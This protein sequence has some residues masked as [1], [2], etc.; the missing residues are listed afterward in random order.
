MK[1][2][3]NKTYG[4]KDIYKFYTT[5]HKKSLSVYKKEFN[6]YNTLVNSTKE[7]IYAINN[8]LDVYGV[9]EVEVD[10]ID[11][12][13]IKQGKAYTSTNGYVSLL[14]GYYSQLRKHKTK[15]TE[16][17]TKVVRLANSFLSEVEFKYIYKAYNFHF[18]NA[19]LEGYRGFY[20]SSSLGK[21]VIDTYKNEGRKRGIDWGT[22]KRIKK[23]LLEKG[24][25]LYKETTN[26][27]GIKENNGGEKWMITY[28][29]KPFDAFWKWKGMKTTISKTHVFKPTRYRPTIIFNKKGHRL[30]TSELEQLSTIE[31]IR[32]YKL[33]NSQ[34]TTM[35]TNLDASY[36]ERYVD[37]FV[38]KNY[39]ITY[40]V[41]F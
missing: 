18:S 35:I 26:E 31:D 15:R 9:Y 2:V 34:K 27:D 17:K 3:N 14:R 21:I 40:K 8:K 7:N 19:I 39:K 41:D 10:N 1:E 20:I 12:I 22:S 36:Y 24:K 4:I 6:T 13:K 25:I 23:E 33:G 30:T 11:A 38:L 37:D 5:E 16:Y 29:H 32:S 28:N